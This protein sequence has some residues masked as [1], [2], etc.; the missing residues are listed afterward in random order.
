MV[1]DQEQTSVIRLENSRQEC[2][3]TTMKR[4]NQ[5]EQNQ[6]EKKPERL[7]TEIQTTRLDNCNI[8]SDLQICVF[9]TP[10]PQINIRCDDLSSCKA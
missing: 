4:S 1:P 10:P 6:E 7:N 3:P 2:S 8:Q 9:V 5:V